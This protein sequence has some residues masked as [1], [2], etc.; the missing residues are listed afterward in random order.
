MRG[1]ARRQNR[2]RG[3]KLIKI[4]AEGIKAD[5]PMISRE[6]LSAAVAAD[7]NNEFEDRPILAL[8]L[9]LLQEFLPLILDSLF[10]D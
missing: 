2:R 10:D 1:R 6:E 5:N 3:I 8:I 7:L 4:T 9:E